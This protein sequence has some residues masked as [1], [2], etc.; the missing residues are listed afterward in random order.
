MLKYSVLFLTTSTSAI[1]LQS[2]SDPICSTAG[3]TQYLH[4]KD[5]DGYD[6]DYFV[7]NFGSDEEIIAS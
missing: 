5:D 6:K 4:P 1:T 2:T 7:P 3:C